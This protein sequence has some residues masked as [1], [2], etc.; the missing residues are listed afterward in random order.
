[1]T[2]GSQQ[3]A[4]GQPKQLQ[5]I[6]NFMDELRNSYRELAS[7]LQ[8]ELTNLKQQQD[9]L[10]EKFSFAIVAKRLPKGCDLVPFPLW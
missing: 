9:G 4:N 1:M 2:N 10:A 3:L 5:D 6:V 7:D 8:L